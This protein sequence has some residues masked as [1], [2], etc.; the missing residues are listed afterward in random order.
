MA[1]RKGSEGEEEGESGGE[2]EGESGR[3]ECGGICLLVPSLHAPIAA[4]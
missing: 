1:E 3:E 2:E 4:A